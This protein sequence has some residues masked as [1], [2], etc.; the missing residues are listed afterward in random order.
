MKETTLCEAI[1]QPKLRMARDWLRNYRE[2]PASPS[3]S[4][5]QHLLAQLKSEAV[6]INDQLTAKAVWC[7]ETIGRI[8]SLFETSF[9]DLV[10]DEFKS[11]WDGLD[12]CE[13]EIHFLDRHFTEENEEFG[14][15]HVRI[16][17]KQFQEL[18]PFRWGISPAYL[19]TDI[20]CSICDARWTLR[21]RCLHKLGEIYDGEDCGRIIHELEILH[22]ALVENPAQKYSVIFPDGNNDY[23]F[24]S[25]KYVVNGL[26]NPWASWSYHKEERRKHNPVFA[27]VGRNYPCPCGSTLKYKHC[28]L[29]K[30]IVMPHFQVTFEEQPP[31]EL[32]HL[33]IQTGRDQEDKLSF[34]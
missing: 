26:R 13:I 27:N 14:I 28:C 2:R 4:E 16:H 1:D 22:I 21:N 9:S 17:T 32:P 20:R 31:K 18:Y 15:E 6:S 34:L 33:V 24:G 8:Q 11:A 5:Y 30:E 25:V 29:K 10:A 7:L 23:R 12:R 19:R 3:L